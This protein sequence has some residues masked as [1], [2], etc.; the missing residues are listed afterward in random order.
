MAQP[1]EVNETFLRE[2]DENLRRDQLRDFFKAYG[3]WLIAAVVL[4]LAASGGLIWWKQ[5][6]V[7]QHEAEVE[8]LAQ[9]YK[10]VGTGNNSQA[11][12]QFDEL[13]KSDSKAVRAS[14]LFARAAVALQQN[15]TKLAIS[16]FKSVAEDSSLPRPYRDAALVRQTALEFDQLQPQDVIARLAPLAKPGEPWFGTAGEMT[17]LAMIKQGKRQEAGQLFAAIA[18]DNGVPQTIRARAVQVAG[19]LGVDASTAFQPQAQ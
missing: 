18:K 1:P 5:H 6:R 2:V 17:A 3:N 19:S 13:S 8:K 9:V 12:Q 10:D 16:T 11:Q 14:A 4:F 7:Q 15:D